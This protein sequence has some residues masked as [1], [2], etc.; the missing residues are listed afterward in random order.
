MRRGYYSQG[1]NRAI[2]AFYNGILYMLSISDLKLPNFEPSKSA[3]LSPITILSR[4]RDEVAIISR[5]DGC[6]NSTH[7]IPCVWL[8]KA[9]T[10]VWLKHNTSDLSGATINTVAN[11]VCYYSSVIGAY[12]SDLMPIILTELFENFNLKVGKCVFMH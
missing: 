7:W 8:S 6:N 12:L 1:H 10:L 5:G 2:S 4:Q 3:P 9:Q 11:A